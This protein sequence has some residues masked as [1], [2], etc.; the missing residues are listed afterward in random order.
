MRGFKNPKFL[1][2]KW[3]KTSVVT[4]LQQL[5]NHHSLKPRVSN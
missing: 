3:A 4:V 5:D 2:D 1:P